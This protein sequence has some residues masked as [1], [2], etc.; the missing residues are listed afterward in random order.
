[1]TSRL[2]P[3]LARYLVL[4]PTMLLSLALG[5]LGVPLWLRLSTCVSF[6]AVLILLVARYQRRRI[7][8]ASR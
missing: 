8:L 6:G 5:A 2:Y 1:M 7:D 4:A 3:P